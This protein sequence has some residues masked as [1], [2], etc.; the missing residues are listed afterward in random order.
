[1]ADNG[2]F[3]CCICCSGLCTS[4]LVQPFLPES[5]AGDSWDSSVCPG[6]GGR[7]RQWSTHTRA[8]LA[9]Q[10]C[11]FIIIGVWHFLTAVELMIVLGFSELEMLSFYDKDENV[12]EK[13]SSKLTNVP[14]WWL[15]MILVSI[16]YVLSCG[17]EGFFQSMTYTYGLCG[18]L[19]MSPGEAI[20]SSVA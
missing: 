1:M 2:V 19:K 14:S 20:S 8:W 6:E 4:V 3:G 18:P 12:Q 10:A 5:N 15:Y 11:P 17:L 9:C 16:Y 7:M 13:S